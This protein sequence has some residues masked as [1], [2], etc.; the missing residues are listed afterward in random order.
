MQIYDNLLIL[1]VPSNMIYEISLC[2]KR[3]FTY[4]TFKGFFS[5]MSTDVMFKCSS[6][7]ECFFADVAFKFVLMKYF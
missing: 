3:P 4:F 5:S 2:D 1:V 6:L 7:G